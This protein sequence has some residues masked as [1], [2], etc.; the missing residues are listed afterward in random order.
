MLLM[1]QNL[2][3]FFMT[4]VSIAFNWQLIYEGKRHQAIMFK[5]W[6]V[7]LQGEHPLLLKYPE[8]TF[9]PLMCEMYNNRKVGRHLSP[10]PPP[11][12]SVVVG[13]SVHRPP[14]RIDVLTM[15]LDMIISVYV[16]SVGTVKSI[17][18]NIDL[19]GLIFI[20]VHLEVDSWD[21]GT[22]KTW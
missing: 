16:F 3:Q 6:S 10:P 21:R 4:S 8:Q 5:M 17:I 18:G 19:V 1:A 2:A 12:L 22:G 20:W 14:I 9:F 11:N 15:L 7:L 13:Q